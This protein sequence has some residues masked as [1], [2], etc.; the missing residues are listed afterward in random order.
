MMADSA[1]SPSA[2]SVLQ[3]LPCAAAGTAPGPRRRRC[4]CPKRTCVRGM[5]G[6]GGA[7]RGMSEG[8]EMTRRETPPT[9]GRTWNSKSRRSSAR[10]RG[11]GETSNRRRAAGG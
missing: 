9:R 3:Q 2:R 10:P 8:G 1:A 6:Q 5:K 4:G 11:T 7:G